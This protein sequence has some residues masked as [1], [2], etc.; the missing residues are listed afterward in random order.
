MDMTKHSEVVELLRH[1]RH[2]WLN[3]VQLIKG[4]IALNRLDRVN[5]IIESVTLQAQNESKLSNLHIPDVA[6]LLLTFNWKQNLYK[7]EVEVIGEVE[8]LADYERSVYKWCTC[9]FKKL[10][11]SCV[12][13]VNNH[14]LV[15]FEVNQNE[16]KIIFDFQGKIE[17]VKNI[18]DWF[19]K[20]GETMEKIKVND[21]FISPEEIVVTVSLQQK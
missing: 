21:P 10:N 1:C 17:N 5:E 9:F 11:Q 13:G 8:S 14:L 3:V 19:H 6:E 7:L 16:P 20:E 4:N 2:D 18:F 15:T 12:E